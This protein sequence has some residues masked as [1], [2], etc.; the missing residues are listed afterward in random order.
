VQEALAINWLD[1]HNRCTCDRHMLTCGSNSLLGAVCVDYQLAETCRA[2]GLRC[3]STAVGLCTQS[4]TLLSIQVM[5]QRTVIHTR[6]QGC[7]GRPI[8][9]KLSIMWCAGGYSSLSSMRHSY[10]G[11]VQTKQSQCAH[12]G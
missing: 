4:E 12:G 10:T 1:R 5:V 6:T 3:L 11:N 2:Y 9:V 7:Q 8:H